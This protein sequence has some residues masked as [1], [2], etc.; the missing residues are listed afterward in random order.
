MCLRDQ[1]NSGVKLVRVR[2][3]TGVSSYC[4]KVRFTHKL[5]LEKSDHLSAPT[6]KVIKF[7]GF[8]RRVYSRD[9]LPLANTATKFP[10]SYNTPTALQMPELSSEGAAEAAKGRTAQLSTVPRRGSASL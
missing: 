5:N 9:A 6:Y 3:P 1:L 8:L 2:T 7:Q 10:T 4:T